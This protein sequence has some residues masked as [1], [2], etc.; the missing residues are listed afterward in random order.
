M[1]AR[2]TTIIP[3]IAAAVLLAGC[4]TG[5][6]AA[7]TTAAAGSAAS[8]PAMASGDCSALRSRFMAGDLPQ[9]FYDGIDQGVRVVETTSGTVL[10]DSPLDPAA[11]AAPDASADAS[12]YPERV[13]P[14]ASWPRGSV[15]FI[16][17]GSGDVVK[18]VDVPDDLACA[19]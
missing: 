17:P 14:K 8:S 9:E 3:L 11:T 19:P 6:T 18:T 1:P 5:E 7:G 13:E 15:V 12:G 10:Q 2:T 4:G 16:D